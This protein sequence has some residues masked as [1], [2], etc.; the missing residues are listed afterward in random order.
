[1]SGL[2]SQPNLGSIV[3][4]LRGSPRDTGLSGAALRGIARYFED[5]RRYYGMFES[6]MRAGSAEV[7]LHEMP[8]GQYTN[9]REQA[10]ALG[11]DHRWGQVADTYAAVNRMFGDI[12]KVTPTSKVVGDLAVTMVTSGLSEADV[13]DPHK[14]VAFP[15]SVV[16]FFRG[17]IGQP[18][19]GFPVML[20]TKVLRGAKPLTDR[21]GASLPPANLDAVREVIGKEVH[22]PVNDDDLAS[23][24]MYP[25]VYLEYVRHRRKFGDISALPT[26]VFF[27]GMEPGEEISIVLEKGKTLVIRCLAIGEPDAAGIREI[28]FEL[29]GQPRLVKVADRT[30]T[31]SS[32]PRAKAEDGN[33]G[34]IGAPMPGVISTVAVIV[35]QPIR[36]GDIVMTI[37]AMKMETAITAERAGH[38]E[39]ILAPVGTQVDV[40]DL[41]VVLSD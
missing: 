41:L 23:Y 25:K 14:E 28:F 38:V 22:R 24:L 29:N 32:K 26:P 27:Y 13:L 6:D 17:D 8:G 3:E 4:A 18:P 39:T 30:A 11:I 33:A 9:L 15:D 19:G 12:I 21:P 16:S 5:V 34:H 10:R 7:Y 35:G 20:Q 36:A 2:T 1:M 37:E 40:K 31:A